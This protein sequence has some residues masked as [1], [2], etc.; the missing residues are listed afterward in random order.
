MRSVEGG[1]L[2]E[3]TRGL[4]EAGGQ[5]GPKPTTQAWVGC[6]RRWDMALASGRRMWGQAGPLPSPRTRLG[7]RC[8]QRCVSRE[9][10]TSFR[11]T[12]PAE[13]GGEASA[14]PAGGWVPEPAAAPGA[15]PAPGLEAGV[16]QASNRAAPCH[17]RAVPRGQ[18][19]FGDTWQ[20]SQKCQ[21]Q[22]SRVSRL[23]AESP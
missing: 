23:P 16:A 10:E 22:S 6:R 14:R 19:S 18:R 9:Q 15:Q 2:L 5:P 21:S 3:V 17:A 7:G 20:L 12:V 11:I 1:G 8:L 4:D 13:S